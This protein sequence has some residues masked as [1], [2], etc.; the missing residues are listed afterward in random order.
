[1]G[2]GPKCWRWSPKVQV[3]AG[4]VP[5]K[6]E[7]ILL[8]PPANWPQW[9]AVL[10]EDRPC[11][12]SACDRVRAAAVQPQTEF[13]DASD[14]LPIQAPLMSALASLRCCFRSESPFSFMANLVPWP[15]PPRPCWSCATVQASPVWAPYVFWGVGCG[16]PAADRGWGCFPCAACVSTSNGCS[17][18]VHTPFQ[19]WAT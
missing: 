8:P 3:W 11:G 15:L 4:S 18:P 5:F 10:E 1:M 9:G 13:R 14:S 12:F 16:G 6:C 2:S 7:W 19:V 17:H